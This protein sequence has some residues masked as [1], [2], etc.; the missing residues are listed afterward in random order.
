MHFL[1]ETVLRTVYDARTL[2]SKEHTSYIYNEYTDCIC[3][4]ML[5]SLRFALQ[6]VVY[7][8]VMWIERNIFQVYTKS[9]PKFK[10]PAHVQR[11]PSSYH[12]LDYSHVP[13]DKLRCIHS[14]GGQCGPSSGL[15]TAD[16]AR[17][18][19]QR[20]RRLAWDGAAVH[21]VLQARRHGVSTVMGQIL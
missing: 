20:V 15:L 11:V 10:R 4:E 17:S 5:H 1:E 19:R 13:R 9:A 18:H 3:W 6:N 12:L 16:A 2:A 7:F 14:Y 21:F 8:I